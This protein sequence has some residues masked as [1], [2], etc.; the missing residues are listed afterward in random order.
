MTFELGRDAE[1]R[2]QDDGDE[3]HGGSALRCGAEREGWVGRE[4]GRGE[5]KW[6]VRALQQTEPAVQQI[7]IRRGHLVEVRDEHHR[8]ITPARE[9]DSVGI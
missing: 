4:G 2:E 9:Q 5:E 3:F 7:R 6:W 8:S 1:Q